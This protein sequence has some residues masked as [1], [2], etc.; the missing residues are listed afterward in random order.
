MNKMH[1]LLKNP[2]VVLMLWL[3][4][5]ALGAVLMTLVRMPH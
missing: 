3:S 2:L 4:A 1:K 5:A